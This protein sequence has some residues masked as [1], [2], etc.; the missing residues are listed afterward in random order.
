M[1]LWIKLF[2]QRSSQPNHQTLEILWYW[3][4]RQVL[5]L[6][7]FIFRIDRYFTFLLLTVKSHLRMR[8][9]KFADVSCFSL[10]R[11]DLFPC[12]FRKTL[13]AKPYPDVQILPRNA[14]SSFFIFEFSFS[15]LSYFLHQ[16]HWKTWFIIFSAWLKNYVRCLNLQSLCWLFLYLNIL[17]RTFWIDFWIYHGGWHVCKISFLM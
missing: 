7:F 6:F 15:L 17:E 5:W 13:L 8:S 2:F 3:S 12:V 16:I 1:Y 10:L 4:F 11:F 14:W 9:S